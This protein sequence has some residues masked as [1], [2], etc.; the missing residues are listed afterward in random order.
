MDCCCPNPLTGPHFSMPFRGRLQILM[1][2]KAWGCY[3]SPAADHPHSIFHAAAVD[4]DGAVA[5]PAPFRAVAHSA[6]LPRRSANRDR[7]VG[8]CLLEGLIR[9]SK[10]GGRKGIPRDSF[11][12]IIPASG[13]QG[14]RGRGGVSPI[15]PL[16]TRGNLFS[17]L[18]ICSGMNFFEENCG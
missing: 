7:R 17:R 1:N 6:D 16:V 10:T 13:T 4:S 9:K 15:R 11:G 3:D 18:Q 12:G 5:E 14:V 8:I 2:S